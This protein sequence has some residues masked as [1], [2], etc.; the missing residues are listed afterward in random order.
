MTT[1]ESPA[2]TD[3]RTQVVVVTGS[4][5]SGTST[6]AGVLARTGLHVPEPA[7]PADERN[8]RGY[9]ES[10]WVVQF[11]GEL[12]NELPLRSID[13]RPEAAELAAA[14]GSDPEVRERIRSW[15]RGQLSHQRLVVKDPRLFWLHEAWHDVAREV[16]A[17][18]SYLSMLR[19][20]LEV[21]KSRDTA[22]LGGLDEV[23]RRRRQVA[24]VAA[25]VNSTLL[26]ERV[27]RGLPRAWV[28]YDDLVADWRAALRPVPGHLGVHLDVDLDDPAAHPVDDFVDAGLRRSTAS[29][30]DAEVPVP[31]QELA[32]RTWAAT[33]ELVADPD[34]AATM[35]RLDALHADYR[36]YHDG[37]V[38][39]ATDHT[40]GERRRV[41]DEVVRNQRAHHQAR[42]AE[43]GAEVEELRARLA[44]RPGERLRRRARR[45]AGRAL[46]PLR[47]TAP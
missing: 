6:V 44:Q 10:M 15:L 17:D 8:P 21:A 24:N 47:R 22:Y 45:A 34:G 26:A 9:Y 31:L 19:H 3:Q 43:L 32:E 39:V 4:G 1:S 41:R 11:H 2:R 30:D 29:W 35:A 38:A 12:L 18:L 27:T 37:C 23:L 25:W 33:G 13:A 20:P 5:R 16:G 36:R 28:R 42:I 40:A 7:K 46:R 14:V